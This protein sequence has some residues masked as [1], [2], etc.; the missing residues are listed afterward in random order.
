M[1]HKSTKINWKK[2]SMKIP[3][4]YNQKPKIKEE[5]NGSK[6]KTKGQIIIYK[7]LYRATRTPLKTGGEL[8]CSGLIGSSWYTND[9]RRVR[10]HVIC[11]EWGTYRFVPIARNGTYPW[12][13]VIEILV[14]RNGKTGH[15]GDGKT[16]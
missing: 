3:K 10:N 1:T 9:P 16:F 6:K 8:M 14:V 2:K 15:G 13:F 4:G 5:Q 7:T 11:H 12:A